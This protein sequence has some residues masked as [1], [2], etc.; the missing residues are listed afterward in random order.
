MVAHHGAQQGE[1]RRRYLETSGIP[2]RYQLEEIY[3]AHPA[4]QRASDEFEAR[5]LA[6]AERTSMDA[7]TLAGLRALRARGLKL[8]VSSNTGQAV[9]DMFVAREGFPFDLALGF[10][11]ERG[12]AKGEPHVARVCDSLGTARAELLFLGDSLADRALAVAS[13]VDFVG[14]LGTFRD[15][16]FRR[17]DPAV[18]TVQ[19]VHELPAL[20]GLVHDG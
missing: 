18:R 17:A 4:N 10:D 15:E 3:P 13:S 11:R 9:V 8:I 14:R 12:L 2:F 20:L 19:S 5:K 1:A 16:D 7:D 6:I